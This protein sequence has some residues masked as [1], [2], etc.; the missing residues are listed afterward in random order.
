MYI[1]YRYRSFNNN[2]VF[3]YTTQQQNKI[4]KETFN[5]TTVMAV[6][7]TCNVLNN[8]DDDVRTLSLDV[9]LES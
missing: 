5:F 4:E 6:N 1:V 2:Y 9:L 7:D 3:V 8:I